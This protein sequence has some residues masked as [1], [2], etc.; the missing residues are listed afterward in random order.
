MMGKLIWINDT[1]DESWRRFKV[2]ERDSGNVLV[3][4]RRAMHIIIWVL[5]GF[6]TVVASSPAWAACRTKDLAGSFQI[7]GHGVF[8]GHD[9]TTSCTITFDSDGYAVDGVCEGTVPPQTWTIKS[10]SFFA[11]SPDCIVTGAV[12]IY[13]GV[14]PVD[15][16]FIDDAQFD[17]SKNVIIGVGQ[18]T[19]GDN[20]F[21]ALRLSKGNR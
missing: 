7:Y 16:I 15:T 17:L 6:V 2:R 20:V 14:T 11:V 3:K 1:I 9:G 13:D 10:D 18:D 21:W 5:V 19:G 4:G 12:I 8:P